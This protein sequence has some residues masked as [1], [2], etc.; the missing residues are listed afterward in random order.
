MATTF[1]AVVRGS[2]QDAAE[3][4]HLT[5]TMHFDTLAEWNDA[6]A[7]MTQRYHVHQPLGGLTTVIDVARGAGVGTLMVEGLGTTSALLVDLRA[8][9]YLPGGARRQATAAFIRTTAWT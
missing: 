2:S 1:R 9:T 8:M 7:L 4:E 6:V 5:L 3:P